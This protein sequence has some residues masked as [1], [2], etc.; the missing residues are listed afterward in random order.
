LKNLGCLKASCLDAILKVVEDEYRRKLYEYNT[1]IK[2]WR[3]K[4]KPIHI[5]TSK[6]K[7]YVYLGRYWYRIEYHRG[8]LRWIY[9]G[10]KKPLEDLPDPPVNPLELMIIRREGS[11]A[12]IYVNDDT[13]PDLLIEVIKYVANASQTILDAK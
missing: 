9:L 2:K 3:I 11:D 10:S 8:R 4:L 6:G 5:V 1:L 12:C 7:K 13:H